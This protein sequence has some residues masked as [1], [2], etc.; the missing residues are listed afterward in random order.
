MELLEGE[1]LRDVIS[2]TA[3]GQPFELSNR[4]SIL[5][6]KL[7]RD[8]KRRIRRAS[9][10]ATSNLRISSLRD[11]VRRRFWTSAL[12]SLLELDEPAES[13]VGVV[14]SGSPL[15]TEIPSLEA[16]TLPEPA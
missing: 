13:E 4:W 11:G 9:F 5:Q 6:S 10:I 2:S 1:T 8:W 14:G 15:P 16:C 12:R 7:P 3:D